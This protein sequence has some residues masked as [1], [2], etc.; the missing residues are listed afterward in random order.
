MRHESQ[1]VDSSGFT[2]K[3]IYLAAMYNCLKQTNSLKPENNEICNMKYHFE[4]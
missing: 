3:M 4:F 2:K 1:K